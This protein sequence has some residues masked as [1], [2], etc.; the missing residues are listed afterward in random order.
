MFEMQ[1]PDYWMKNAAQCKRVEACADI[2]PACVYPKDFYHETV[3]M[4]EH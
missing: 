4:K 1:D 3:L 2:T